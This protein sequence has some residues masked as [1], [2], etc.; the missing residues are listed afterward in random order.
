LRVNGPGYFHEEAYD[1]ERL[2]QK[3]QCGELIS[4]VAVDGDGRVVGHCALERPQRQRFGEVGR[5]WSCPS[6]SRP[7][8]IRLQSHAESLCHE[9]RV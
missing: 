6:A 4:V 8:C 7:H 9:A 2:F 3:N 1:P 5:Q